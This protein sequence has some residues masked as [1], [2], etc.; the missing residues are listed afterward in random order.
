MTIAHPKPN[1]PAYPV[2]LNKFGLEKDPTSTQDALRVKVDANGIIIPTEE[3]K[4]KKFMILEF[5]GNVSLNRVTVTVDGVMSVDVKMI[6]ARLDGIDIDKVADCG[7][8]DDQ[9]TWRNVAANGG[10]RTGVI[11][12]AYLSGGKVV[13]AESAPQQTALGIEDVKVIDEASN[14][15]ELHF[16]FKLTR[17]VSTQ[18]KL[19]FTVVK[20]DPSS[21]TVNPK[22]LE[23]N[24]WEYL[25]DY[26]PSATA[27]SSVA[28]A[29]T[30]L[31]VRGNGFTSPV[32]AAAPAPSP[33]TVTLQ[34]KARTGV[35]VAVPAA[36]ITFT[37]QMNFQSI[38]Q[39]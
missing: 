35:P 29:G 1:D 31:T 3:T 23:S 25:V 4:F 30:T 7:D 36:A 12:G 9:C 5:I 22:K 14:D 24:T 32:Q 26:S 16:S 2:C 37:T 19:H 6:A 28:L 33:M 21:D 27:I 17:P 8:A 13:L 34:S 18:T 20:E 10:V 38:F 15:N 11:R 39:R